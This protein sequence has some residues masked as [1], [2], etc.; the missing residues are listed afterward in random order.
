MP[1]RDGQLKLI[2]VSTPA[3]DWRRRLSEAVDI[4]LRRGSAHAECPP[5]GGETPSG[6]W[7]EESER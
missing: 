2:I 3:S 4:C 1:R 7:E 5:S 6:T